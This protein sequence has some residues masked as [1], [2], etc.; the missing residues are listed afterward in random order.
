MA[1]ES[2]AGGIFCS[3]GLKCANDSAC[4]DLQGTNY[5]DGALN[6]PSRKCNEATN[7]AVAVMGKVEIILQCF[8]LL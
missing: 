4:F 7:E 2:P 1:R 3:V 6:L 8:C 5:P